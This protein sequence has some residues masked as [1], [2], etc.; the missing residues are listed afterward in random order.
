MISKRVFFVLVFLVSIAAKASFILLPMDENTQQNHLKAY[1]ITFWCLEKKFKASWLLNYR[2]GSFLLPDAPEIRKECQIRGVSFEVLSDSEEARI[3]D[4]I[5]S[6]SQNMETVILEKAPRIAVYTPKGKQLWDDAVT[7]V[8]TYAEIPFTPI[9]DEEVLSDQLVLYDW[10]HLHHEDFTGQYG[11]FFG[12]YRN[13]PWYI[14]DKKEAEE[15]ASKLGFA[16]VSEEKGAVAKKIR[17]FVVGGGFMF[18]M[19]SATDSFDIALAA[20][21]VDICEPM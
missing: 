9:Y 16:K 21:G 13:V 1:G 11:K 12:A 4:E 15:L 14:E 17:N 8:L 5:S 3:L 19:C 20:D 2:G 6:P 18:A 10:L 7:L